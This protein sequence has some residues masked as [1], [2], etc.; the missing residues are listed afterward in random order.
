MIIHSKDCCLSFNQQG[1][2]VS[3]QSL[4]NVWIN[5]ESIL[6][7]L[8]LQALSTDS[9]LGSSRTIVNKAQVL[10]KCDVSNNELTMRW[11]NLLLDNIPVNIGLE[12][13]I[14]T[15]SE[16]FEFSFCIEN[17]SSDW[18]VRRL[19]GPILRLVVDEQQSSRL[20][21]PNEFGA[22]YDMHSLDFLQSSYPNPLSM[23]WTAVDADDH[24]LYYACHNPKVQTTDIVADGSREKNI[25]E[26][27]WSQYPFCGAGE[28]ASLAPL[29][30]YPYQGTWHCAA[31]RY[32]RWLEASKL[33]ISTPPKAV[34]DISGWQL[35]IMKQQNGEIIW[36]YQD[37]DILIK[38]ARKNGLNA[39]ALYGWTRGGH[40]RHY[41]IYEADSDMGGEELLRSQIKKAKAAGILV[42]LYVNGQLLDT[43]SDWFY[44]HGNDIVTKSERG[45]FFSE[46]WIKYTDAPRAP[47]AYACQSS[48][49]WSD[50]L[51]A[52]AQQVYELGANG[53][54]YDQIGSPRPAFCFDSDHGHINAAEATGQGIRA[55]LEHIQLEMFKIDP[56][57]IISTEHV[58][59]R[60]N[61]FI[62]FTHGAGSGASQSLIAFPEMFRYT[63]PEYVVTQ[64]QKPPVLSQEDANWACL[65]GMRH[66]LEYRYYADRVFVESNLIPEFYDY[67][68][69]VEK[70]DISYIRRQN[71][72]N[73][74]VYLLKLIKFEKRNSD[75]LCYGRFDD[76][77]NFFN[78]NSKLKAKSFVARNGDVGVLVWNSTKNDQDIKITVNG[79]D[80][81]SVDAPYKKDIET[82]NVIMAGHIKLLRFLKKS[83]R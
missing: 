27:S 67:E 8:R 19:R 26:L 62:D 34:N 46:S 3:L 52:L 61:C 11:D 75:L 45:E 72:N 17:N 66:E 1:N 21:W 47:M 33:S 53:I 16:E 71:N 70:P 50:I 30:I 43:R 13:Q 77:I 56:D 2:I 32:R 24:G 38:F 29:I 25:V 65:Y 36:D 83:G 51:L 6:W 64:R 54:I 55:N 28:N 10:P 7:E 23:L 14:K 60:I 44:K 39:L 69:V 82:G 15:N 79:F 12:V 74:N 57:F 81:I 35:V 18:V 48:K 73:A 42:F 9:T 20:L 78:G 4:E 63:L 76:E 59:D 40:D 41:P 31:S 68:N 37:I 49:K 58:S 80:M 22:Q 5:Q